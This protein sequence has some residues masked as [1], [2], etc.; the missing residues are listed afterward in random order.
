MTIANRAHIAT[1][2]R[3]SSLG[4]SLA[5]INL[6]PLPLDLV[7]TWLL[8]TVNAGSLGW[9]VVGGRDRSVRSDA[10]ILGTP[11]NHFPYHTTLCS[12]ASGPMW[13]KIRNTVQRSPAQFNR[14]HGPYQQLAPTL[15][16]FEGPGRHYNQ[17]NEAHYDSAPDI[18]TGYE[19][20]RRRDLI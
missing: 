10:D 4:V 11:C 19:D 16:G 7:Q 5:L 3:L 1:S 15:T 9:L 6:S 14:H 17:S 18:V 13:M 8:F 20:G 12:P 2:R